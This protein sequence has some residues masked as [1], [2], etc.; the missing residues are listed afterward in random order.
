[1]LGFVQPT[2]DHLTAYRLG[3]H[4]DFLNLFALVHDE[5]DYTCNSLLKAPI[6]K[7]VVEVTALKDIFDKRFNWAGIASTYDV[8]YDDDY[9]WTASKAIPVYTYPRNHVEALAIKEAEDVP[10]KVETKE[11]PVKVEEFNQPISEEV[12]VITILESALTDE[13]LDVIEASPD[14]TV[15]INVESEQGTVRFKY[16][17]LID[18]TNLSAFLLQ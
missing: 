1:M 12:N 18:P 11:Q 17:R 14:G 4:V 13:I 3:A 2:H 16:D 15:Q 8:E 7:R 6:M 10:E 9:A 5:A